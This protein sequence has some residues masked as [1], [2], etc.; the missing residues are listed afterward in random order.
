MTAITTQWGDMRNLSAG[1]RRF[2]PNGTVFYHIDRYSP[3]WDVDL[4]PRGD[5]TVT[6]AAT[7]GLNASV[8]GDTAM[9]A[10]TSTADETWSGTL[11]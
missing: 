4:S 7:E 9:F 6:C 3:Y 1:M 8:C 11:T 2:R 5:R 10:I